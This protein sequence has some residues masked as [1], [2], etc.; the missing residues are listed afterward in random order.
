M[1]QIALDGS[2]NELSADALTVQI[3]CAESWLVSLLFV[4]SFY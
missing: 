4:L 1:K 2:L 3:G